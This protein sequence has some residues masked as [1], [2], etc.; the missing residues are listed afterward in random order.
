M[1]S[2]IWLGI[3]V[4][5]LSKMRPFNPYAF[6]LA[7][8]P[9]ILCQLYAKEGM[10]VLLGNAT[11]EYLIYWL[12]GSSLIWWL[13]KQRGSLDLGTESVVCIVAVLM[14]ET[15]WLLWELLAGQSGNVKELW[16]IGVP[17]FQGMMKEIIFMQLVVC[18]VINLGVGYLQKF[19]DSLDRR[20][21]KE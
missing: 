2:D 9:Q 3:F 6:C 5:L 7:F 18:V 14:G 11:F 15:A 20:L 13:K 10:I 4:I 12:T 17:M 1:T 21:F 16:N 19:F 8:V